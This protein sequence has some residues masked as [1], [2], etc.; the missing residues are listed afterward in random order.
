M[1]PAC[2]DRT[3]DGG[4]PGPASKP[5]QDLPTL[6]RKRAAHPEPPQNYKHNLLN[7]AYFDSTAAILFNALKQKRR[8]TEGLRRTYEKTLNKANCHLRQISPTVVQSALG[9]P[10]G[11]D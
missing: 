3:V 1:L 9:L 5:V 2:A 8:S 7:P 4:A 10:C 6:K 11:P